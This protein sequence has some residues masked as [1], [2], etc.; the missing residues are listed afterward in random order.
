MA[1]LPARRSACTW[2]LSTVAVLLTATIALVI[3]SL[4]VTWRR[5][6][7]GYAAWTTGS[8]M[9]EY[10]QTHTNSWPRSWN[11]LRAATNSLGEKGKPVYMP[12]DHLPELVAIDWKVD[13]AGLI[14]A[15][16]TNADMKIRAVTRRDGSRLRAFW[17]GN[18]E[19]NAM[20]QEQL[21][22]HGPDPAP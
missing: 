11:D 7:E 16:H 10:L 2:I 8:L 18:A 4:V 1:T 17:G 21:K 5:I 22:T 15:L 14:Q 12:L 3:V 19:P 9:V 6:P 20:I 13:P